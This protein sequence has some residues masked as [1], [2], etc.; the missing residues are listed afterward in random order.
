MEHTFKSYS[1]EIYAWE[2][3]SS[4]YKLSGEIVAKMK[5][6]NLVSLLKNDETRLSA[7]LNKEFEN[8][9]NFFEA[10]KAIEMASLHAAIA[11]EMGKNDAFQRSVAAA[12][13]RGSTGGSVAAAYINR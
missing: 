4:I 11:K 7:E 5:D 13:E 1:G 6:G 2:N 10:Y 9:E 12:Q 8:W 3:V